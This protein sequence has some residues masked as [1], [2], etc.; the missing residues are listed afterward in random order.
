MS[1]PFVRHDAQIAVGKESTQ[2]STVTNAAD[3]RTFGKISDAA[4]LPDPEVDWQ[5]TRA[6]AGN[7]R[8]LTSKTAGQN[9]YDGGSI[10]VLPV[11]AFPFEYLFGSEKDST[12]G[13]IPVSSTALPDT[14]T[15]E[16]T[17]RGGTDFVRT[18]S[19]VAPSSGTIS[20]DNESR[21][22]IDFDLQALGVE[23]STS[24]VADVSTPGTDP[25]LYHDASSNLSYA[26]TTYAR[27]TDFEWDLSNN[28]D[29]RYYIQST[30]G[31][32]PFEV[33]YGNAGH[34]I[35][36]DVVPTD[37]SLYSELLGRSD[38]GTGTITFERPDGAKLEF[39]FEN[40][41]ITD[42][43]VSFPDEGSPDQS[44]SDVPDTGYV[45]Y[46]APS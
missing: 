20:V 33:H 27:V 13:K 35:T 17:Y 42:A 9:T 24:P 40:A 39:T 1:T 38:G 30:S 26:G 32:D 5:E 19:G 11:D 22:T 2:G 21:L 37:D 36:F 46:T 41:G 15:V 10:T 34:D 18:F 7:S 44:V 31:E 6:I 16:A 25:W 45:T 4:D 3:F 23:T 12:T 8:E 14:L 28:L 29:A 43:P